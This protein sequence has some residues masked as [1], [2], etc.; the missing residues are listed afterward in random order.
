M[1]SKDPMLRIKSHDVGCGTNAGLRQVS[2]RIRVHT[3]TQHTTKE[4][5][6]PR[7]TP[8]LCYYSASY[9]FN[10]SCHPVETCCLRCSRPRA[11]SRWQPTS[12]GA[13][14]FGDSF[15]YRGPQLIP[16][17]VCTAFTVLADTSTQKDADETSSLGPPRVGALYEKR[18]V[19]C[20]VFRCDPAR[21]RRSALKGVSTRALLE[22]NGMMSCM[23]F[24]AQA[25]C[26][27]IPPYTNP[28][29]RAVLA[30]CRFSSC[31]FRYRSETPQQMHRRF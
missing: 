28:S 17:D 15:G 2:R 24:P 4:A 14:S 23:K 11:A 1:S 3:H 29:T 25:V 18:F 31:S 12:F 21:R 16:G 22:L 20:G 30:I 5:C 8:I 9:T 10:S 13:T 6:T 27:P 19:V 7:R 26:V